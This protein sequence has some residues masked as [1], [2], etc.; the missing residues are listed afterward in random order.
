MKEGSNM[1]IFYKMIDKSVFTS[2]FAIPVVY[3]ELLFEYLG[4]DQKAHP[5]H[6]DILKTKVCKI[7]KL[8]TTILQDLKVLYGYRCQICGQYIGEKYD[9]NLIYAHHIEYFTKSLNNNTN[10][11]MIL[12]PNHH[13]IIHDKNPT[14]NAQDKT[15][16]YPNGY[17]EG[18]KLNGHL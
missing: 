18:L 9:S 15:F 3:K 7:R 2:G 13:G 17:V 10:N 6:K 5:K 1:L 8:T 12:C 4:F 14:Y 16:L 11:I